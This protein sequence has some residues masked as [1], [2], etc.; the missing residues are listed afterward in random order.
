VDAGAWP[1]ALTY[2]DGPGPSTQRLLDVLAEH[3]ARATLFC[4]G[5]NLRG[6]ALGDEAQAV[7]IA[8]RAVREGHVL[9]NHT[10][11]HAY[12]LEEPALLAEL[13]ECDALLATC[14]RTAGIA[15]PAAPPVRL[16]F[17]EARR[18][19]PASLQVLER[20]GRPHCHWT[21]TFDDWCPERTAQDIADDMVKHVHA[22]WQ[23][24]RVP[25]LLLHD[26]GQGGGD[27]G[28]AYGVIRDATVDAL[29]K[30][31]ARLAPRKLR[32]L[33]ATESRADAIP[34]G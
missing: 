16:P 19:L 11:S 34:C 9:G 27:G 25:V 28:D 24:G 29:A 21:A 22:M 8:A 15:C 23:E 33:T 32:Y 10:I 5:R 31:C 26:A 2:D 12:A 14:Y 6:E 1:L 17:G 4:L 30:F 20:I 3:G 18:D 13:A 7:A